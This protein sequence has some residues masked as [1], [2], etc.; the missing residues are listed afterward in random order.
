[1]VLVLRSLSNKTGIKKKRRFFYCSPFFLLF[2]LFTS[3][4]SKIIIQFRW[5]L[6]NIWNSTSLFD[7]KRKIM[8]NLDFKSNYAFFLLFLIVFIVYNAYIF[9]EIVVR[10]RWNLVCTCILRFFIEYNRKIS[11]KKYELRIFLLFSIFSIVSIVYVY[12]FRNCCSIWLKFVY[13]MYFDVLYQKQ[14]KPL[15]KLK[16]Y[17]LWYCSTSFSIVSIV[18]SP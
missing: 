18:F 12:N 8:T 5:K 10:F 4:I 7:Y 6:F 2:S 1:M 14:L 16:N 13:Y 3:I 9:S 11:K 15:S 17:R